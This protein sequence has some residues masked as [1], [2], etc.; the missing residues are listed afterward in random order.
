M[1]YILCL[2]FV[3]KKTFKI[4]GECIFM[5][6]VN[7]K[8]RKKESYNGEEHFDPA[9]PMRP[10]NAYFKSCSKRKRKY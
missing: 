9:S 4:V 2:F 7:K 5:F 10:D 6:A 3:N 8:E 1:S